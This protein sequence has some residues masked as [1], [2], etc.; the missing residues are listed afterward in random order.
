MERREGG[1]EGG[2]EEGIGSDLRGRDEEGDE[3]KE[4][5]N[6]K[7][8]EAGDPHRICNMQVRKTK[9]VMKF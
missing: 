5:V 6:G 9:K 8:E 7:G 4:E 3:K 2:R 1:R